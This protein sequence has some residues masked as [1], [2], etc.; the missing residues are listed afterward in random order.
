MENIFKILELIWEFIINSQ[1]IASVFG[2][3]VAFLLTYFF[4]PYITKRA[5]TLAEQRAAKKKAYNEEKGKNAATKEDIEIITKKIEE[6]KSEISFANQRKYERIVEQEKCLIDIAHYSNL[7]GN[8]KSRLYVCLTYQS[9]RIK[10]DKFMEDLNNYQTNLVYNRN[11]AMISNI[12]DELK[13]TIEILLKN[14]SQYTAE[15]F[16][17]AANAGQIIDI[18]ERIEKSMNDFSF[19][20]EQ[21]ITLMKNINDKKDELREIQDQPINS[22]NDYIKAVSDYLKALK[23]YLNE[24]VF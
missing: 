1:W 17:K 21:R 12:D 19:S 4:Y 15:L 20:T 16:A 13:D 7:I 24:D 6:I 23:K 2:G 8:M 9:D 3:I 14:M 11:R 5:E 18:C 10:I 22:L